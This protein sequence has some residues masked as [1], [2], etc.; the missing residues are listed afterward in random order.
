MM[1]QKM[2][3]DPSVRQR[4]AEQISEGLGGNDRQAS[5]WL[6]VYAQDLAQGKYAAQQWRDL[7]AV[8]RTEIDSSA[9]VAATRA[10]VLELVQICATRAIDSGDRDEA[11]ALARESSDLI[12]PTSRH[13]VDACSWAID[14]QLH[15]FV[16]DLR[17]QFRSLFDQQ[18]VLLYGAAEAEKVAGN[19][20]AA[21]RLA[22]MAL[23]IRPFPATDA[24]REK[25]SP[26]DI[27]E[28]AQAHLEIGVSLQERGLFHWAERE[29]RK[30][31]EHLEVDSHPSTVVRGQLAMMLAELERHEAVVEVLEPL[32]QRVEKDDKMKQRLNLMFIRYNHYRSEMT[33]HSAL[34]KIEKGDLDEARQLL[35]QAYSLSENPVDILISMYHTDGDQGWR[36]LVKS[37]LTS[38]IIRADSEV[39]SAQ[40]KSRANGRVGPAT[41]AEMMNQYA[42]LVSNTEG[43]YKK[44]LQYSLESLE[45]DADGAKYDTCGRCYYALGDLE[46]A[47]LMQK[48]AIKLMPHSPPLERQ[49]KLF[50][51]AVKEGNVGPTEE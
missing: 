45:L 3:D 39:Q 22:D 25:M 5:E 17:S 29:Y 33:Y 43:D 2:G 16:L 31:I 27:E 47:I 49:L 18:P 42:W 1:Q 38:A 37:K 4:A 32:V 35:V 30:I 13:L 15:P 12:D 19:D 50:E 21:A 24:E 14:H 34:A 36:Q 41:V 6:R 20:D 51:Q 48:R 28:T 46:N 11:L 10:S 44:A 9:S 7:I 26:R 40:L 23:A 8:Q